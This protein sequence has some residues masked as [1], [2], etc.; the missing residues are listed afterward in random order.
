MTT[1]LLTLKD[2]SGVLQIPEATLRNWFYRYPD[3]LPPFMRIGRSVR[4]HPET[5][6]KWIKAKD[7][8][9]QKLFGEK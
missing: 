4:F 5:V 3:K 8:R 2:L 7:A 1:A 6:A 9:G